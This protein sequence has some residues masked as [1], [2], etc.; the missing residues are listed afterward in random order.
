[1]ISV[2]TQ[3]HYQVTASDGTPLGKVD[4][5]YAVGFKASTADGRWLGPFPTLVEALKALHTD[6]AR[7]A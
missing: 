2:M 5:D 1:M 7:P 4:G 6:H 3:G